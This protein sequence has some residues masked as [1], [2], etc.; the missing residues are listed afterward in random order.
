MDGSCI[1]RGYRL[2]PAGVNSLAP[3]IRISSPEV[4][5]PRHESLRRRCDAAASRQAIRGGV[6]QSHD[7][8]AALLKQP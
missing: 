2:R 8:L 4:E 7:L 1:G 3:A 6:M 5:M